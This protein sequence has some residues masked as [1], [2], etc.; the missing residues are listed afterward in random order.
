[1]EKITKYGQSQIYDKV[2]E[3]VDWINE[4]EELGRKAEAKNKKL[5]DAMFKYL[6]EED[7]YVLSDN[8]MKGDPQ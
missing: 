4:I 6:T 7:N 2:N 3:I 1:M 8:S 5:F